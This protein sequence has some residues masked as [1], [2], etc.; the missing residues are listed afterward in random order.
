METDLLRKFIKPG[1]YVL[2]ALILLIIVC[3]IWPFYSVPTGSRGVVTAFGKI[4]GITDEGLTILP[5]WK[6]LTVF[7]VRAET[8][9]VDGA[10]G[11]TKDTQPVD[12]AL[13]VRYAISPDKVGFVYEQYSHDGDLSSYVGTA[14]QEV[15]KAVTAEYVATD[16]ITKR[17]EVS[18]AIQTQL[19]LKLDK[20]GA[21][22]LNIDMRSFEFDK[23]YMAAISDKVTQEQK[24]LAADNRV[25]TQKAEQAIKNVTAEADASAARTQADADA[26]VVVTAAK[27]QAQALEEQGKAIAA[28]PQVVELKRIEV[29]MVRA[30]AWKGD[31]PSAMYAN[32]P[33]PFVN[34]AVK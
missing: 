33:I 1:L 5:P 32:S 34:S 3:A 23:D 10:R 29:D 17:S 8:A 28:N 19:Q 12:T 6:K 20:Y 25:Q 15:F 2:G 30:H 11:S 24:K 13:T 21:H 22:V 26:Y 31:V 14:V 16:L 27:A 9:D 4:T 18:A 7:N